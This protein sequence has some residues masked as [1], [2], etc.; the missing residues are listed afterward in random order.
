MVEHCVVGGGSICKLKALAL[1]SRICYRGDCSMVGLYWGELG[2]AVD[3]GQVC[4][5]HP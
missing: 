5:Y 4:L 2:C 3:G 1:E